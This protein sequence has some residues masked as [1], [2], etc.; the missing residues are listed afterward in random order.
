MN[1]RDTAS[2][3]TSTA[4]SG[5]LNRV[6]SAV[7]WYTPELTGAA[8]A[9]AAAVTVWAPLGAISAA[10]GAWIATDQVNAA[11]A[12]RRVRREITQRAERAQLNT[13][14]ATEH[15]DQDDTR[16][17]DGASAREHATDRQAAEG[18]RPGWEVAG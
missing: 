16:A 18:E 12:R 14:E 1:T 3:D 8:V 5:P 2:D 4:P 7:A 6:A 11:R 13:A 15:D 10:L 9:G 17:D